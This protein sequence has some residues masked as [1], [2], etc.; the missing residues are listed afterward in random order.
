MKSTQQI[1]R[2]WTENILNELTHDTA[3]YRI[4]SWKRFSEILAKNELILVNP[5]MWDDPFENFYLKADAYSGKDKVSLESLRKGCFGQ[6]WTL[7]EDTD[8][9]W[10][11][12]SPEKNGVRLKTTVGKLFRSVIEQQ[13]ILTDFSS[14][15]GKVEYLTKEEIKTYHQQSFSQT[16][17]GGQGTG[18][19]SMLL[20]KRTSFA[21]EAEVRVLASLSSEYLFEY[22]DGLYQVKIDFEDMF[23]EIC[24]DP[25]L[26]IGR[27]EEMKTKLMQKTSVP[28]IQS[29][30]YH[31]DFQ[32]I[33]LDI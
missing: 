9:M 14:Y 11:I 7:N 21:H 22:E 1:P 16:M 4:F 2:A 27:F 18:F 19:A 33:N 26:E 23:D 8:A 10:R 6:C 24:L 17:L 29:D 30:L 13:G 28:I 5:D 3:I 15:I 31:F 32:P 25:R 12:Y 20:R